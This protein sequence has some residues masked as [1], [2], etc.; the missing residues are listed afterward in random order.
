MPILLYCC[1]VWGYEDFKIL[2]KLHLKFCKLILGVPRSASSFVVYGELGRQPPCS[3]IYPT[4][5]NANMNKLSEIFYYSII[6]NV[7]TEKQTDNTP[8]FKWFR[9]IGYP[10]MWTT[11]T[12]SSIKWLYG[13]AKLRRSDT[14]GQEWDSNKSSSQS[15]HYSSSKTELRSEN[16]LLKLPDS[17]RILI[18]RLRASLLRL[19]VT[20]GR[21]D[22]IPYEQR[23]CTSCKSGH[24]GDEFHFILEC[25]TLQELR[26]KYIPE[27]FWKY[28]NVYGPY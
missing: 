2:E 24:I 23:V 17:Q 12:F 18:L 15:K 20:L 3:F 13:T 10:G 1:E 22:N 4:L 16:Y 26:N 8:R 19:P 25:Q 6:P 11:D 21:Y 14:F 5:I 27:Y 7:N 28:P 9:H